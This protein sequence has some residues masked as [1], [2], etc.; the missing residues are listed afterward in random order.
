MSERVLRIFAS[1]ERAF[2]GL[3]KEAYAR[4]YHP[5]TGSWE[6]A[7]KRKSSLG[8]WKRNNLKEFNG[9]INY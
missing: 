8:T 6:K 1:K 2:I 9:R 3:Q 7:K 5:R 4:L